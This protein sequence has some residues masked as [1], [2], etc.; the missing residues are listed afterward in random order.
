MLSSL[1]E[2]LNG[3]EYGARDKIMACQQGY[4]DKKDVAAI[5]CLKEKELNTKRRV[6]VKQTYNQRLC[7]VS[8]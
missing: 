4:R 8:K 2:C 6:F 1:I 3:N 7:Q 5:L